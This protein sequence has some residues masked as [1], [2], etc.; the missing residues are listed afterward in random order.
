[1][2]KLTLI[3][4]GARSGKSSYAER[5]A[6]K[7]GRNSVLYVATAEA[8]DEEMQE[9]IETHRQ[10]RPASWRTMET[11]RHV[12]R[13]LLQERPPERIVLLDCLTLLVSNVL[14]AAEDIDLVEAETQVQT[15]IEQLIAC[16]QQLSLHLIVVSNEVGLGLV[17]PTPLGR[18]YRDIL[19][20]ANQ[21]LA[22][23]ADE[24]FFL[25]AGI[26][27]TIKE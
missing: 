22:A 23:A 10:N 15:E 17:P 20:R 18:A 8:G 26:P 1:M 21:M 5:L 12:G 14:T 25:V 6:R 4:G 9:R 2:A 13:H 19:G 27:M 24:V 7:N 3:L 16:P 11:P